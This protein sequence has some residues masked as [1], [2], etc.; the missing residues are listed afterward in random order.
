MPRE[1]SGLRIARSFITPATANVQDSREIDFQLGARQGIAIHQVLG[2][3]S[4]DGGAAAAPSVAVMSSYNGV[5]TLHL[6]TGSLETVP[7]NAGE[8]EDTI[9]TEQ[10]YRQDFCGM[11]NDDVSTEF[12]AAMALVVN[13]SGVVPY[14][15]PILSARNITHAA[16]VTDALFDSLCHVLIFYTFVEFSL[17][18]LGLILARRT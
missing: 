10:F 2:T 16:I 12:R 1:I 15:P 17:A 14:A 6:E 7:D 4:I 11:G 8:D 9:D 3:W 18:E 5:Q 13:P